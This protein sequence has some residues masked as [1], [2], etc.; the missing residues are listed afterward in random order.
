MIS[1][2]EQIQYEMGFHDGYQQALKEMN[3]A[4]IERIRH[5]HWINIWDENDPNTSTCGRCTKCNQVSKRP[6]G[7]YCRWC[8]AK[9]DEVKTDG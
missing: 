9:M 2:Q 5:G 8:G 1:E 7:R 6:L 4:E 3:A